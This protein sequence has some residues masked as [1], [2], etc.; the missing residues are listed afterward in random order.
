MKRYWKCSD[1]KAKLK[2][3]NQFGIYGNIPSVFDQQNVVITR[4]QISCKKAIK[5]ISF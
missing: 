1:N 5:W 2:N 3:A 4:T